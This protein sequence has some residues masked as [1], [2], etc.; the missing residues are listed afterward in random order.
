ML[1]FYY[2]PLSPIARRVW[3]AL[4]EKQVPHH[5]VLVDLK[6]K[7]NLE[8]EYL[9]INPFHHV[10]ALVEGKLRLIESFAI[11]DYLDAQF[12][13]TSLT[14]KDPV[15]VAR[16][17]MVQM[18]VANELVTKLPALAY[19]GDEGAHPKAELMTHVG[20]VLTFL[21]DELGE[22]SFFGGDR[23]SLAD[24]T[25]GATLPLVRRLG[26][27]LK[28]Y[29]TL[30]QWCDRLMIRSAWQTT[31]PSDADFQAWRRWINLMVKRKQRQFIKAV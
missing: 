30:D 23:L 1:T 6:A 27:T 9:A 10:P 16:M 13:Q 17:R 4:L 26:V 5:A 29:P 12:P 2:H 20:T 18:V 8:P 21:K 25:A 15:A 31:E 24:I 22:A 3:L 7:A 28:D 19:L 11:L 14:P